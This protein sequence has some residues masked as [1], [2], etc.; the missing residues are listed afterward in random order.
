VSSAEDLT[1]HVT[2]SLHRAGFAVLERLP[3]P[4]SV[5]LARGGDYDLVLWVV[6]PHRPESILHLAEIHAARVPLIAL[7]E[8]GSPASVSS[9]LHAGADACLVL[10]AD[11]RVLMAQIHAVLRRHRPSPFT[12]EDLGLI[13]VGDLTVN[14]DRC[15][16][17]RAGRYVA[18]TASEFRI[19]AHMARN[20][21]R[22]M[23]PHEILNAVTDDYQYNAREAQEVFK[24]YVRRI[25]QKLEPCVAEPRYL[26]TVRGLGYRLESGQAVSPALRAVR[27]A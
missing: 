1:L 12:S 14:I 4:S 13:E 11:S 21:G 6:S 18:L 19:M 15:E 26:V 20:A 25:R 5:E 9:C 17:E 22:V 24:V 8:D 3:L 23:A 2:R 10:D 16:V 27:T 7:L